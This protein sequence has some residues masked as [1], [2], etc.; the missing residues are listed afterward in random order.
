MSVHRPQELL[1]AQ[2]LINGFR[3][4]QLVV[5]ACRPQ[6][7]DLLAGGPRTAAELAVTT[8]THPR[9]L[10]RM[11]RGLAA[12][13]FLSELPDG[14]FAATP[15]SELFR[16]D[17]PG[18]RNMAI[19]LGEEGYQA[20]GELLFTLQTGKPA[21]D[22]LFGKPRWE[23]LAD[24]PE[25]AERF[26]T[27]MVEL[28]NRI[29]RAFV[30]AYDF[31]DVRTI[32]DVGGGNG[33]MLAGVLQAHPHLTGTLFDLP[34][35]LSGAQEKLAAAGLA[36]RVTISEGSFFDAV[37]AGADLYMLK[38]IVHDWDDD[39]A[40]AIL[41]TCRRAMHAN[42]RLVLVE[43]EL[44][45]RID[46]PEVA[47]PTVMSD[48]HMMIVLGGA[49]RTTGEYADLLA[50]ADLRVTRVIPTGTEFCAVEAVVAQV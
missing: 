48:L 20:W 30:T 7:P 18:L 23:H 31:A 15:M 2:R 32:V 37:P 14:T 39:R 43:R 4:Y 27:A 8:Q 49:E 25:A 10:R 5:A 41:K 38:S 33:A 36:D 50:G 45:D 29:S 40:L 16:A 24:N 47:L 26:N 44:P 34:Q 19:M 28:S 35:G 1:D 21:F 6:L 46:N 22:H 3:G 13:G 9:S 12:W 42:A 17:K 11:I